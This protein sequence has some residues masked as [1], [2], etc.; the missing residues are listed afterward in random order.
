MSVLSSTVTRVA[1]MVLL[2]V[3]VSACSVGMAARTGGV[4]VEHVTKCQTRQC[5]LALDTA[6]VIDKQRRADGG[7][8]ETYRFQLKR[9][10]AGRAAMHGLLDVATLGVWEVVGTPLEATKKRK[11]IVIKADYAPDGALK[12]AAFTGEPTKVDPAAP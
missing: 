4:K 7:L 5:F 9:G 12:S 3:A 8:T 2:A 10:S 11:Y 6:E 1:T